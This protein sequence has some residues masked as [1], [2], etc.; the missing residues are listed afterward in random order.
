MDPVPA[1]KSADELPAG[2]RQGLI[3]AITI[4]ISFSLFL[5]KYWS[6]EA[7]GEWTLPG[8]CAAAIM[9]S[10]VIL[11]LVA[12]WRALQVKDSLLVEYNRTL[13]WFMSAVIVMMVGLLVSVVSYSGVPDR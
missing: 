3:T 6:L 7:P 4:F 1:G 11:E 8:A 10:A 5:V 9:I 12:L 13:R 2:Y